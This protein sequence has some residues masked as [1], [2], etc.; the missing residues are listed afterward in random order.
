MTHI[1]RGSIGGTGFGWRER[2]GIRI[3]TE[4]LRREMACRG[5]YCSDLAR[6]ADLSPATVSAVMHGRPV[7]PRTLRGIAA[8]LSRVPVVPGSSDLVDTA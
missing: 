2:W 1:V 8:A 3:D 7:S 5:L 4:R 6:R